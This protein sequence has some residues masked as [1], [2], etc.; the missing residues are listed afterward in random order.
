MCLA[1]GSA[2]KG[3]RLGDN[4]VVF[5]EVGLSGE[6]RHVPFIDHRLDEAKKIGFSL[7]IGPQSS[8]KN[9]FL[10]PVTDVKAAL[11]TFLKDV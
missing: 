5:G 4:A 9:K 2:A 3:L 8:R 6:I 10:H 11:N 7:A 1:V